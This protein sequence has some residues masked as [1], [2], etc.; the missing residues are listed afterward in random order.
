MDYSEYMISGHFYKLGD[1]D[2]YL[3]FGLNP[4][5]SYSPSSWNYPVTWSGR[6]GWK[7]V[8]IVQT[9]RD[10]IDF[11][12]IPHELVNSIPHIQGKIEAAI[13]KLD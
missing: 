1:S 7:D 3:Q 6:V 10:N 13:M 4:D 5:K 12:S 11:S 9:T 8:S 2:N